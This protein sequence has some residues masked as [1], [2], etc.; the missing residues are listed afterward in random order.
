MN[1][2]QSIRLKGYDYSQPGQYFI[3]ICTQ[4]RV[5]RF[6]EISGGVMRLNDVGRIVAD[7]WNEIP[8]HFP[9][10][11]LDSFV[12]MPNHIH[13]IIRIV[14][15]GECRGK[16]FFAP[17]DNAHP[18][19]TSR[20]VGS[21]VRGL[22]IGITKRFHEIPGN[23]NAKLWQRNYWEHIIRDE[24]SLHTIRQYIRNNPAKWQNDCLMGNNNEL[25]EDQAIYDSTGEKFFAPTSIT[26]SDWTEIQ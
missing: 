8:V 6:G 26:L 17:T 20:T 14:D 7:C 1:N 24:Q 9:N 2:R 25:R 18:N 13:G 5:H 12:V 19:G 11:I 21:I 4:N 22:K 23:E 15:M 3:T 16:K 10:V